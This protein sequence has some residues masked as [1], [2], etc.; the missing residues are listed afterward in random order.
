[1]FRFSRKKNILMVCSGTQTVEHL[2]EIWELLKHDQ[3]LKF[4][5]FVTTPIRPQGMYQRISSKLNVS[6][7]GVLKLMLMRWDLII[8]PDHLHFISCWNLFYWPTLRIPHGMAGKRV[9]GESWFFGKHCF[10]E[11]GEIPYTRI[12]VYSEA[13]MRL[14]ITYNPLFKDKVVVAGNLKSDSLFMKLKN[15]DKI[16]N[17]MGLQQEETLILIVSTF[18]PTSLMNTIGEVLLSEAAHLSSQF[19]FALC[20]HPLEHAIKIDEEFNWLEYLSKLRSKGFLVLEP[21]EDW[22]Y[23]MLACDILLTDHTSLS[24]Y[25]VSLGKSFIY[26]PI[27]ETAIEKNGFIWELM[28]ISPLL[29][30]DASNLEDCIVRAKN[31]YCKDKLKNLNGKFCSFSGEANVITK[32][33]IY[34]ILNK[35]S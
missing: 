19:R 10:N 18:G 14:A 3:N 24:L 16:R 8:L 6:E 7:I 30:S 15:R 1:M 13:E 33:A 17:Q 12:L 21:S 35:Y 23:Y 5:L 25:G 20:I 34:D 28:N 26:V 22:E 9:D 32:S 27:P 2:S 11:N 29:S 31:S 4:Y